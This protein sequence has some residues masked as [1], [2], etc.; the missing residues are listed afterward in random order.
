M[1]N[2]ITSPQT[3]IDLEKR[4]AANT[5]NPL[6]VFIEKGDGVCVTDVQGK[7]Y[8]DCLSAYSAVSQGHCHP[9]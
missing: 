5:Y 7:R 2:E 9:F 8:L 1:N 3:F 6:D 4:Y